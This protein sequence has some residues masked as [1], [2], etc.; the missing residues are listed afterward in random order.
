M[1]IK[2]TI[3]KVIKVSGTFIVSSN[4]KAPIILTKDIN[5]SSGP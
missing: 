3:E 1:N 4:I 2:G 5:K